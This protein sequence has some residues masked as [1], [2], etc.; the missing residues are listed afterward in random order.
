MYDNGKTYATNI[1]TT[2][3]EGIKV[4]KEMKEQV[5][6]DDTGF[7][8]SLFVVKTSVVSWTDLKD[9]VE[10]NAKQLKLKLLKYTSIEDADKNVRCAA[11]EYTWY[12]TAFSYQLWQEKFYDGQYYLIDDERVYLVSL[13]SYNEDDIFRFIKSIKKIKCK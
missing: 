10:A 4:M 2:D 13:S 1:S 5:A 8:N 3:I 12:I 9:L 6:K 7:V 11:L